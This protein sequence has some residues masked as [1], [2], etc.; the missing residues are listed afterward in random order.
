MRI[1]S[2]MLLGACSQDES[3]PEDGFT[4]PQAV[5]VLPS[6]EVQS[7][8]RA[9]FIGAS[10]LALSGT[11]GAGSTALQRLTFNSDTDISFS[12]DGA[13]SVPV[14]LS[15]GINI[16]SLRAEDLGGQR[17]V[18]GR[19]VYAGPLH[20][21][22]EL[23]E[24]SVRLQLGP[25][26]LDDDDDSD[27]DDI[28]GIVAYL[29]EDV[30][31]ADAIVGQTIETSYADVT[32]TSLDFASAS[33]DLVPTSD[34]ILVEVVLSDLW[35]DFD[36]EQWG[37]STDGSIWA[38]AVVLS[39]AL[40]V[41]GDTV[42]S[43]STVLELEGYGGEIDWLP[44]AILTWA[45]AYLEAELAATTEALVTDLMGGY[46]SAFAIDTELLDGVA[47]SVSLADASVSEAGLLLRLDASVSS[48]SGA[49]PPDAGSAIT[50]G[51]APDWPLSDAPFSVAVDDDLVNQIL[52]ALWGAGA[53]SGF[54][55]DGTALIA[56][57]GA[58]IAPPLGPLERLTLDMDLPPMLGAATQDD[59]DADLS[60]G[61]WR[62]AFHRD[63]GELLAF[64][65]NVRV[66]AQV[67]FTDA[68]ALSLSLDN[69]PSLITMAVGVTDWPS[70]LDAGDLAALVKLMVPPLLGNADNF[71]PSITLPPI[72]LGDLSTAMDGIA[73][74]PQ[75]L[76]LS[77]DDG[78]WVV[79]NGSFGP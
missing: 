27:L 34:V 8:E 30:G 40:S 15:P 44:D 50:D 43:S 68:D 61:E 25:E 35:M 6:L 13:F 49:L 77:V 23:L 55:Y 46:L 1:F 37:L 28:A 64:S 21:P 78:G 7:P 62:M 53:L 47:L 11:V 26:L 17:A 31:V 71:L 24:E 3:A 19:A 2:I 33:V 16:F 18:D 56:L 45:E 5:V 69:R 70:S 67:R 52:F 48:A 20:P 76:T 74:T 51:S 38:D 36:A 57:T 9:A 72:E 22:G 63:D 60:L 73:L 4:T 32:P 14:G 42:T 59:M 65:V 75:A 29:L 58:E 54:E 79:L 66:G 41:S 10:S 39:T 12:S